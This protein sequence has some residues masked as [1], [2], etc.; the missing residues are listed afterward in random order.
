MRKPG[1]TLEFAWK[2]AIRENRN[3]N[4]ENVEAAWRLGRWLLTDKAAMKFG[5]IAIIRFDLFFFPFIGEKTSARL[6]VITVFNRSPWIEPGDLDPFGTSVIYRV[7]T[8]RALKVNPELDACDWNEPR[9]VSNWRE[10]WF[11]LHVKRMFGIQKRNW[12]LKASCVC[13]L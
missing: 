6:R 8:D 9:W 11:E 4:S 2:S 12:L 10:K 1:E 3:E 7:V 13:V 5:A